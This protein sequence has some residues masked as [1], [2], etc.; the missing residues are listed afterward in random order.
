MTT[1]ILSSS[2]LVKAGANVS[3]E[4]TGTPSALGSKPWDDLIK[5]AESEINSTTRYNWSA[6]YAS[7][8]DD[9]KYIYQQAVTARAAMLAISYDTDGYGARQAETM[10]DVLNDQ[11]KSAMKILEETT[12]QNYVKGAS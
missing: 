11:Y 8:D 4:F 12:H 1:V 3:T 5:E 6:N 2:C 10:L 9:V 7:L